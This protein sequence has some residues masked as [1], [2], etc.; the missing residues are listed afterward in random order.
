VDD[1]ELHSLDPLDPVDDLVH[2]PV[3]ADGD[4]QARSVLDGFPRQVDEVTRA[5]GDERVAGKPPLGREPGD[6]GP[7]LARGAVV[8]RRV[9]EE[10]GLANGVRT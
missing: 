10:D 1:R 9:D 3:A 7:A 4:E 8:G 6:L 2:G 5:L